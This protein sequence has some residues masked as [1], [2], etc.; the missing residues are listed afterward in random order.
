MKAVVILGAGF[1]KNSGLPV[2]AE[3]PEL[4]LSSNHGSRFEQNIT[5]ILK[6]FIV[7]TFGYVGGNNLPGI[8]DLFTCI[9]I[10]TNSGH[11]LGIK[12]SP[13]HLRALRRF[14]VYRVFSILENYFQYSRKVEA[15]VQWI[16][17][18]FTQIDYVVL[19]WDT[20]LETYIK[21]LFPEG[22]IDYCNGGLYWMKGKLDKH[23]SFKVLKV[24][25]SSNW[26]YCDNCR[27]LFCDIDNVIPLIRRAG[28]TRN[29]LILFGKGE[30]SEISS[31]DL[32]GESCALCGN[33]ISSHIATFSYRKT[34]RANSFA[35][36]WK[37]AEKVLTEADKWIF[38]GYSLPDADY[39]FKHLLKIS[40]LK[41]VHIRKNG[42]SID[43][44]LSGDG[45]SAEKY[46][47]LF[48]DR[49]SLVCTGGIDE[50]MRLNQ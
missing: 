48:G 5:D 32:Q 25:G 50:Y 14:L 49:I 47:R 3:I 2:Q 33:S 36:V 16:S 40:E 45:N 6:E 11:H 23:K 39:E 1:S 37:E 17:A 19:N 42:L 13:L 27:S 21:S 10:S 15:F 9:D 31:L 22:E 28:F 8:D 4:L 34:F 46:K 43:T 24:H 26:I 44:I 29:D 38:I 30:A 12:Y 41:Q 7:D 18:S 35:N 20:V